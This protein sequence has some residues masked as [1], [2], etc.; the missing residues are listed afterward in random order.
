M[1]AGILQQAPAAQRP[2]GRQVAA[3]CR[4]RGA[5]NRVKNCMI[6]KAIGTFDDPRAGEKGA[7][8]VATGVALVST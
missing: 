8:Q 7:L 1:A 4:I 6:L 2:C 3:A 5:A